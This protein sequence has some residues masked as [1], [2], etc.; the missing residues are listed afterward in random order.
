[1]LLAA[2]LL[3]VLR[4][5]KHQICHSV[6]RA[7]LRAISTAATAAVRLLPAITIPAVRRSGQSATD[8]DYVQT[9][10]VQ[11]AA[12]RQSRNGAQGSGYV[13]I[14]AHGNAAEPQSATSP[15]A[16]PVLAVNARSAA[17]T[18]TR[19]AVMASAMTFIHNNAARILL[20]IIYVAST[21]NPA[22]R[23]AAAA[24]HNAAI[25]GYAKTLYVII[26]TLSAIQH[27]NAAIMQI[28]LHVHP[29]GVLS[30]N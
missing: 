22:V 3:L 9:A 7:Y 21:V 26:A 8:I 23:V 30:T 16:N 5:K 1:M 6:P 12:L 24:T 14:P 2:A 4:V 17:A 20:Q 29:I 28:V 18:R 15:R 10:G 11:T 19:P 25:T 27:T 13:M